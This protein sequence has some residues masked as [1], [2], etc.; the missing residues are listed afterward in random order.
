MV[1][2]ETWW[3]LPFTI[4]EQQLVLAQMAVMMV[5]ALG[6]HAFWLYLHMKIHRPELEFL[7]F[8]IVLFLYEIQETES[9]TWPIDYSYTTM[10]LE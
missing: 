8:E 4:Q 3:I 10:I 6:S 7:L 5:S 1:L 9:Q 2:E